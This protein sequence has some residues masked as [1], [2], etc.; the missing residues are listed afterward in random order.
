[1]NVYVVVKNGDRF[2]LLR[3]KDGFWEFPGGGVDWGEDPEQAGKRETKE[4]TGIEITSPLEFLGVTSAVY[5][6]DGN[7]KHSVYLVYLAETDK[8][9]VSISGEHDE[10]R[11]LNK[12]E[13]SF[14][15]YGLNAEPINDLI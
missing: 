14:L 1:M 3:R 5:E 2:L 11:W 15:K 7:E 9:E 8:E 12:L 13:A 4:E 6:K 10:Y